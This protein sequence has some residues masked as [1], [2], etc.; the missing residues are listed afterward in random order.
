MTNEY[1]LEWSRKTAIPISNMEADLKKLV[2]EETIIHPDLTSQD[3]ETRA[4]HRLGL[5]LRKQLKSPAVG[6]EGIIIGMSD[7]VDMLA[8]RRREAIEFFNQNPQ[9]AIEMGICNINGVPLDNRKEWDDGK[10]NFNFNKPLPENQFIRNV[11]GVAFKTS[12]EEDKPKFFSLTLQGENAKKDDINLFVPLRFRAIDKTPVEL[13]NKKYILNS[14]LFTKFD[15]DNNLKLPAI[16][17]LLKTYCGDMIVK[18]KDLQTYHNNNKD[19]FNRLV[20]VEGDV[21]TLVLEPSSAGSRRIVIEDIENIDLESKGITCWV[22]S[23]VNIDFAE[24]SKV[25]VVGKTGQGNKKDSQGN[26]TEELGDLNI[27]VFGLYAL[28]SYKIKLNIK[29]ITPEDIN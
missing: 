10:A 1:L 26:K 8:K 27:N 4:L 28:P 20:I 15:V 13:L 18:I 14:S 12:V 16:A 17:D 11:W 6:F 21:S 19:N 3:R 23:R 5:M 24:Q 7:C 22:P 2:E 29:T 9:K 25:F